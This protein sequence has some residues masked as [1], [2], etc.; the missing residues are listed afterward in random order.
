MLRHDGPTEEHDRVPLLEDH[1]LES[2]G[3]GITLDDEIA[4]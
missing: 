4:W 1:C 3:Q 2:V